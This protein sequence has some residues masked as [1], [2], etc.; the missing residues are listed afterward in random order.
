MDLEAAMESV[1][2]SVSKQR[3][4]FNSLA[5]SD[6]QALLQFLISCLCWH[7]LRTVLNLIPSTTE[8]VRLRYAIRK[9]GSVQ[10]HTSFM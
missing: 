3:Q 4:K 6:M 5:C 2:Y 9:A 7:M 10:N 8:Q 1:I